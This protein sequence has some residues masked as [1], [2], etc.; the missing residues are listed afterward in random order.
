MVPTKE[1]NDD[2]LIYSSVILVVRHIY[3]IQ[4]EHWGFINFCNLQ[5]VVM[6]RFTHTAPKYLLLVASHDHCFQ[7]SL[8]LWVCFW[9]LHLTCHC[10]AS[11]ESCF[12]LWICHILL[13]SVTVVPMHVC[14]CVGTGDINKNTHKCMFWYS[15][16]QKVMISNIRGMSTPWISAVIVFSLVLSAFAAGSWYSALTLN[17]VILS[18]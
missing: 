3:M 7:Y 11:S 17:S 5:F 15:K 1:Q 4:A 9:F 2:S 10:G 16:Y 6:R 13:Y 8:V 12:R 14:M 18:Q